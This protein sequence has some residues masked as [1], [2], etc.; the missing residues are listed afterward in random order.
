[1]PRYLSSPAIRILAVLALA[2]AAHAGAPGG[3][4]SITVPDGFTVESA[5]TPGLSSYP[6]FLEFDEDGNLYVAESTGTDMTATAMIDSP[7]FMILK[8]SDADNDGIF[9]TRT[10]YAGALTF[11]MG[12]LWH[13]GS[14]YVAAPPDFIRFKD[15]DGDGVAN[16]REVLLTGWNMRNSAS[17]HGPFLGPDGWLYLTHGR[18]GYDITSKEGVRFEGVASR[19][20][21]CKP[22][23]TRLERMAGGAFD[24]PIEVIFTPAGETIGTM[25]YFRDPAQG[26][27]DGLMHWVEGGVFP[28]P[29]ESTAE[30][31]RT[32]PLM[33]TMTKF[34]RI[35]PSGLAYYDSDGWGEE[36]AGNL[37]SAQ[38]NP[39]RVQRHE[40][41]RD[42]AT[43]RTE[44]SDFFVSSHPDFHPTDVIQDAD[45]SLLI[46]DTG[47]WYVDA[48]PVSRISKPEITGG[49]YRV[50]KDGIDVPADP[51]GREI[52]FEEVA[53]DALLPL[54]GDARPQ[55]KRQAFSALRRRGAEA[56][57]ALAEALAGHDDGAVRLQA[58]WVLG[59]I[60]GDDAASAVRAALRDPSFEVRI[61]AARVCGLGEDRN[62]A[63]GLT[64]LL[65]DPE[66][67]VRRQAATALGRMKAIEAAYLTYMAAAH[68]DDPF[69]QHALIYAAIQMEQDKVARLALDHTHPRVR[70]AAAISLDQ[71]PGDLLAVEDV[72]PFLN[73]EDDALRETGLWI[74]SGHPEW[75]GALLAR[76]RDS[77]LAPDFDADKAE[78]LREILI[79]YATGAEAQAA[80]AELLTGGEADEP[81]KRF[82]LEIVE[83]AALDKL[84]VAWVEAIGALIAEGPEALRWPAV[85]LVQARAIDAH[86]A[87]ILAQAHETS[88]PLAYRLHALGAI[89]PRLETLGEG[90]AETLLE[91][92]R[93]TDGDPALRQAAARICASAPLGDA[94]LRALAEDVIPAADVL[95]LPNLL[96]AFAGNES[97]EVGRALVT[98]LKAPSIPP[99]LLSPATLEP[100]LAGYPEEVKS[101]AAPLLEQ[102]A[103]QEAERVAKLLELEPLVTSGDVGNGRRVFFGE[104]AACYTCH[105]IGDEGGYLGPDLTTVGLIRS[106]HD[107]LESVLFPNASLVQDYETYT[108]ETEWEIH[109]GVISRQ[110]A[111]SITLMTGVGEEVRI[112]RDE[113]TSMT[114]SPISKMPEGLDTALTREE[115]IDLITFMMSLNNDA[116]LMPVAQEE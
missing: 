110:D 83:K 39:H 21:R 113:I 46:C 69:E 53:V 32:G 101:E 61:A 52:A 18:H 42:G 49:I 105:R 17:L 27:R 47:G 92:L 57:P 15:T 11:P 109:D 97:A 19:I 74:A 115:L 89:A 35:A 91:V 45:G 77:L 68:T 62:A 30:F 75:S 26:Q 14:V 13:D 76:M 71:M 64:A 70:R 90:L 24:N 41:F 84:P 72:L 6:M 23:G 98:G 111:G 16:E 66:P 99:H 67:P 37:Y 95:I 58:V 87:A 94:A 20:W 50:R 36:Y 33:P 86:D 114:T 108:I 60:G 104:K 9:D 5:I 107:I 112:N 79:A 38:F 102:H 55:V 29:G 44:D 8:L 81:R 1:M 78:N 80:I 65:F 106:A 100:V 2:T 73:A 96:K 3:L 4:A 93:N 59:Q 54:L 85:A 10:T 25:T 48:C 43:Y 103:A 12:V 63:P 82:L 31:T 28:K 116:W 88:L 51:W 34:A 40:L 22:D 7:S 56:V